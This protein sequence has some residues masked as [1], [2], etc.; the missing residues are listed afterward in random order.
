M[1]ADYEPPAGQAGTRLH[2]AARIEYSF[3]VVS[4]QDLAHLA[5]AALDEEIPEGFSPAPGSLI[6]EQ[7]SAPLTDGSGITRWQ[8][9]AE[10]RLMRS[11]DS[12]SLLGQLRGR[13]QA[14]ALA[15]LAR[16]AKWQQEPQ[17]RMQPS[18][19]PW[20]P[21]LPFSISVTLQ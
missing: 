13:S 5:E 17:I 19:W 1:E 9:H 3:Q 12:G 10:R 11:V 8:V 20:L 16:T 15:I 14:D 7:A 18:W 2:L 6:F 4:S 21:L